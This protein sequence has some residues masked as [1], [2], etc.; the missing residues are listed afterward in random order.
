MLYSII[1]SIINDKYLMI[2]NIEKVASRLW[3]SGI[4]NF[5]IRKTVFEDDNLRST[6]DKVLNLN[7]NFYITKENFCMQDFDL[8]VYNEYKLYT[9]S[10]YCKD[11]LYNFKYKRI[12]SIRHYSNIF[13]KHN[14]TNKKVDSYSRFKIFYLLNI[15]ESSNI[16]AKIKKI[17]LEKVLFYTMSFEWIKSINALFYELLN[18]YDHDIEK[19][20]KSIINLIVSNKLTTTNA[21]FNCLKLAEVL[22]HSSLNE[23]IFFEKKNIL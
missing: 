1:Y 10:K 2:D 23:T 4:T 22:Y 11:F 5:E 21:Y 19:L 8:K 20:I 7:T 9:N 17:V 18:N 13:Y 3:A 16:N 6:I 12:D 14:T 15:A